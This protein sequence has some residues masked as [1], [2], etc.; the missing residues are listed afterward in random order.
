MPLS[1]D[2]GMRS[3]ERARD[4][5]VAEWLLEYET[6]EPVTPS[7][8]R[9]ANTE[10]CVISVSGQKESL[11]NRR[12][13][14]GVTL[15]SRQPTLRYEFFKTIKKGRV[16]LIF[17]VVGSADE[18]VAWFNVDIAKQRKNGN[19]KPVKNGVNGYFYPAPRSKF[20]KFW[21]QVFG[22][23][24][25]RWGAVYRSMNRLKGKVFTGALVEKLDSKGEPYIQI[26]DLRLADI[27]AP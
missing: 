2:P 3:Q 11:A 7:A 15:L 27:S 9:L 13:K 4:Q 14:N 25:V 1:D 16:L 24:S 21:Q 10:N 17:S 23:T 18:A 20:V 22:S 26:K 5:T 12:S 6:G 8:W 19:P